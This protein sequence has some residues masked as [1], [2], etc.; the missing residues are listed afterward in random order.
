MKDRSNH[1]RHLA[2][3]F[4]VKNSES[5]FDF[6]SVMAAQ[7]LLWHRRG[8]VGFQ[9]L[10]Q[11][12]PCPEQ[13]P[14]CMLLQ[15]PL[16]EGLQFA[17]F[18]NHRGFQSVILHGLGCWSLLLQ[19]ELCYLN[20]HLLL[21]QPPVLN[22]VGVFLRKGGYPHFASVLEVSTVR[23]KAVNA[24][25]DVRPVLVS[26]LPPKGRACDVASAPPLGI[27]IIHELSTRQDSLCPFCVQKL[28]SLFI[29]SHNLEGIISR[30]F[31]LPLVQFS[32]I[33]KP[34]LEYLTSRGL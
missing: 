16:H 14:G 20:V 29:N 5:S 18:P 1:Q 6:T 26:S 27:K 15:M 12:P 25:I 13:N 11:I 4:V 19:Q 3:L 23:E 34:N 33:S 17:L 21:E 8:V 10:L 7:E 31:A 9:I 2:G 22:F 24:D 30:P 32:F 28:L